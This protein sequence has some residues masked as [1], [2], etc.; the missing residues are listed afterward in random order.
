[1]LKIIR[2]I[3]SFP[4]LLYYKRAL[5]DVLAHGVSKYMYTLADTVPILNPISHFI[6]NNKTW[7]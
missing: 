6:N 1:M 7:S 5:R 4:K 3:Y 2:K